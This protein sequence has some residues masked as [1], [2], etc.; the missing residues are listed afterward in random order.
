VLA[1]LPLELNRSRVILKATIHDS[2][3][4]RFLLDTACTIPTLHPDLVDELKLEAS[5]RVR[6]HGIAGIERAPTYQGVAFDLGGATYAPRRVA[7]IPSEREQ[8]RRRRDGVLDSGFLRRFTVEIDPRARRLRLHAPDKFTPPVGAQAIPFRFREEIP[9]IQA[10]LVLADRSVGGEFEIDTGCDSGLCLG[11]KFVLEHKLAESS[12]RRASEKFGI[13]GS[14]A[15]HSATIPLL[16]LGAAEIREVQADFF[17]E[18]SPVD[19][20]LA[21][22]VGMPAFANRAIIFDY[23]RERI[24]LAPAEEAP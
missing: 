8:A 9:V 5:G 24:F 15:T 1:D 18:G 17:Q 13:G 6:M 2:A 3:P 21:G 20:P 23:A 14:V 11:A 22:H 4:L 16:K 10:S 7:S 12:A 19:E